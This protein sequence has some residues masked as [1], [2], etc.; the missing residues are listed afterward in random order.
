[1][2]WVWEDATESSVTLSL[3]IRNIKDEELL[4]ELRNKFGEDLDFKYTIR[5]SISD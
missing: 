5:I 1:M 2:P 3:N 4:S